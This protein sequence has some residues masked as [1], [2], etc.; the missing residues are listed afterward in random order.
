LYPQRPAQYANAG[1]NYLGNYGPR[2]QG[3]PG[4][5]PVGTYPQ[6]PV[7]SYPQRAVSTYPQRPAGSY[8]PVR[9]GNNYPLQP[10]SGANSYP[11]QPAS[12]ANSYPQ[13]PASGSSYPQQPVSGSSYPP[14]NAPGST[15]PQQSIQ[16][17]PQKSVNYGVNQG[18]VTQHY[19]P[20]P[21]LDRET[22]HQP[23]YGAVH[24]TQDW[25]AAPTTYLPGQ[26]LMGV[27]MNQPQASVGTSQPIWNTNTSTVQNNYTSFIPSTG[28]IPQAVTLPTVQNYE[29]QQPQ[30]VHHLPAQNP[31][32]MMPA[33]PPCKIDT[34]LGLSSGQQSTGFQ[35]ST[36]SLVPEP[37]VRQPLYQ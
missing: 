31:T 13:Q 16:Y 24:T 12:G 28:T 15:Y 19:A 7:S 17:P 32:C 9:A 21:A 36:T 33:L 4:R 34:G 14:Q 27:Q 2:P 8:P 37:P 22:V 30:V 5:A 25:N 11:L 18:V 10:T 3:L 20:S 6:R 29:F 1:G 26:P 35:N 23:I